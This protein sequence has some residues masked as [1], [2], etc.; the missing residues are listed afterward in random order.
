MT[1]ATLPAS[2]SSRRTIRSSLLKWARNGSSFWLTN[3]DNSNALIRGT[4]SFFE[5][6][7]LHIIDGQHPGGDMWRY[8]A[9]AGFDA[10][11]QMKSGEWR[12]LHATVKLNWERPKTPDGKAGEWQITAWK[13]E[14]MHW[15]ASP[16]RLFVEALDTALRP[17]Q[18]P[19]MRRRHHS[20][21]DGGATSCENALL[22]TKNP[23]CACQNIFSTS[24]AG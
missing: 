4:M 21:R 11:A 13:T 15:N 8:E 5:H 14:E 10:L 17:P 2:R 12:S 23:I 7:R 22:R 16:K 20:R 18:D 9:A 19:Q 3:G 1:G 24:K 6:A